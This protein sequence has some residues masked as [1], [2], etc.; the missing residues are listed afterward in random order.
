MLLLM[1]VSLSFASVGC[2]VRTQGKCC[3][4]ASKACRLLR[5]P[6]RRKPCRKCCALQH[7]AIWEDIPCFGSQPTCWTHW[8]SH[9]PAVH[10][11]PEELGEPIEPVDPQ[12]MEAAVTPTSLDAATEPDG[13]PEDE[14]LDEALTS[15]TESVRSHGDNEPSRD[16]SE[17]D[18]PLVVSP[19]SAQSTLFPELSMRR[20]IQRLLGM[21][22]VSTP[23]DDEPRSTLRF[24]DAPAD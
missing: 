10:R 23:R 21:Q 2:A 20:S 8:P 13:E 6:V 9:C 22:Q 24:V 15:S 4:G 11:E 12:P 7:V 17:K 19:V 5:C 1:V 3:A 18:E 16:E 14:S